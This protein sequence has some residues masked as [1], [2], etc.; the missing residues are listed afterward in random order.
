ME[1]EEEDVMPSVAEGDRRCS[2][3]DVRREGPT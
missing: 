2:E 3:V 1:D